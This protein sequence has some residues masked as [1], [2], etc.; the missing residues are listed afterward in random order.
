MKVIRQAQWLIIWEHC[1]DDWLSFTYYEIGYIFPE[2]YLDGA[3]MQKISSHINRGE[4]NSDQQSH[5]E[6]MEALVVASKPVS[7]KHY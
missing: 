7:A 5:P 4:S 3:F 6:L 2:I 1:K